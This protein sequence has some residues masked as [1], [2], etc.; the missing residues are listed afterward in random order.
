MSEK[1][2]FRPLPDGP[3]AATPE[4][5]KP[6]RYGDPAAPNAPNSV[7]LNFGKRNFIS[8]QSDNP[9]AVLALIMLLILMISGIFLSI[10]LVCVQNP[11]P[12]V[13]KMLEIIGQAILTIV[14][15]IIGSSASATVK[16]K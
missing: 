1:N 9:I 11:P 7:M 5:D 3:V 8:W 4:S 15:A 13:G 16:K 10:V 6:E 2:T 12:P 14:G